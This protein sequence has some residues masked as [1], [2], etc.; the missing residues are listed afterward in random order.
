MRETFAGYYRPTEE[1]FAL[2]W[3]KCDFV[4]DASVLLNL[5][6]LPRESADTLLDI[7]TAIGD[8]LWVPHQAALEYHR[9]RRDV[10]ADQKRAYSDIQENLRHACEKLG[11]ELRK[12]RR[13]PFIEVEPLLNRVKTTASEIAEELEASL[14]DHPDLLEEDYIRDTVTTVLEGRVGL[15]Y[16]EERLKQI[17]GEGQRRYERKI[18]PGFEDAEKGHPGKYADLVLWHQ[19]IDHAEGA[20][21]PVIF[22]TDDRKADWWWKSRDAKTIGPHPDLIQE[23]RADAKVA[24]YMYHTDQFMEYAQEYLGRRDSE[25]AIQEV[26]GLRQ[27]DEYL[28]VAREGREA[29][30]DLARLFPD[31]V[32]CQA[33]AQDIGWMEWV[34]DGAIAGTTGQARRMEA[35]RIHLVKPPPGT[36]IRYQADVE[37]MGW[38][39][40]VLDGA[41]AGTTGKGLRMEGVRIAL[42]NGPP[43]CSVTYEAHVEGFG[44]LGW[45]SDGAVAGTSG[46]Q[47]RMEAVRIRVTTP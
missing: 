4:L 2:L 46:Q 15:R 10:I 7:L 29:T 19:V 33:H 35:L 3:R 26:R 21:Q 45:V 32:A 47:R 43:G 8:R 28:A 41:T 9:R 22:I 20:K 31:G 18:P 1:D 42:V 34:A 23:M 25:Q 16:P 12:Y 39:E 14:T 36:G 30:E 44:W 17:Y 6:R 11:N 24:F 13:H 27:H 40:W 37:G 5:Y 38:M